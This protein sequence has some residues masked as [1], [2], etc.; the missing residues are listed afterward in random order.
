MTRFFAGIVLG[1]VVAMAAS[2]AAQGV[3]YR[4]IDGDMG[5]TLERAASGIDTSIPRCGW[6]PKRRC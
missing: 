2:V 5:K 1:V 3:T 6:T 4:I